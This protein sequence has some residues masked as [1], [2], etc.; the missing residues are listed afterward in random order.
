M[1]AFA[2]RNLFRHRGRSA[3][4]LG[5]IVAGVIAI[6]V[7]G[8]F[9]EDVFIQLREST[10]HSQ[11][12]HLQIYKAGYS[13][14]GTQ[15]PSKYLIEDP[16]AVMAVAAKLP[17]VDATM[18][19]LAFT[20]MINNGRADLAILGEGVEPDKEAKLG[21][22]IV[23]TQ[24]RQLTVRDGFG[25][26]IGEG[27]AHATKLAPGDRAT[28]LVST[29]EGALNTLDFEIVGTFRS[30]SRDYDARAVRIPL[31]AAQELLAVPAVNAIVVSLK[32]TE[33]TD[34]TLHQLQQQLD[35]SRYEVKPWY[36]LA[37][38]YEKTV[39]LY[40]RQFG[41]LQVIILIAVALSVANSVN[42]SIFE[43]IGEFGTLMAL[44]DRSGNVFRLILAENVLL[45]LLGGIA[46]ALL[47]VGLAYLLSAIGIPMP[48]PP[49][50]NSGY[51]ATIRVDPLTVASAIVIG[52]IATVIAALLPARRVS[53]I[54]IVDALRQN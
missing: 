52:F 18:A 15:S 5:V 26:L 39:A 12:G 14:F 21:T 7:S 31:R 36:E 43:R 13:R 48:P 49:N 8:G 29:V 32:S 35:S 33:S 50:S 51:I 38:F 47:G 22:S 42:M 44:G 27:V 25:M 17:A 41:V 10:I 1:R 20:G 16:G 11:L 46:G 53:R 28:L 6:V 2:L 37:D 3:L 4:T 23:I 9:I 19:R 24:G 40:R 34:A 54:P 45:G 30:M